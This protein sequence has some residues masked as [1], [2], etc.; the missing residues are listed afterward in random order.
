MKPN[1]SDIWKSLPWKKFQRCVFRLQKRIWKAIR[2]KDTAKAK[3][4][5][6]LLLSSRSAKWIAIRQ[7]TQ[8]NTG[9]KTA[10]ID[11]KTALTFRER[12]ELHNLLKNYHKWNHKGLREVPIPKKDGTKRILKIPTIA[13]RAWQC[14]LKLAIEP[15]HEAVFHARSYGFRPG[16]S[17]WDCQRYIYNN[18]RSFCNG[19]NKRVLELDISKC[20]DRIS[21]TAMMKRVIAPNHI[22][23]G[24]WKCLK[25]GINPEFPDQGTPQGGV[26]SPLLANVALD[27]IEAIHPS[28]RYAD[29]MVVFLKPGDNAS[30]ILDIIKSFLAE[31]GLEVNLK[32]T[33]VTAATDGFDFLG[34][35]FQVKPNGK[36]ICTPSKENYQS[37]RAKVKSIVNSSNYGAKTKAQKLAPVVRGWRNYHR[38]CDMSKHSLWSMSHRA[39][40]VFNK[41]KKLN[42]YEAEKLVKKAFL[43]V[44]WAANKHVMVKGDSSPYDGNLLY[45]SKR[46]SKLYDGPTEKVL[47]KQDHTC[48]ICGLSFGP[49]DKV[50]LHHKDGNHNNWKPNNLEAIHSHCHHYHHM[51]N[52]YV[53]R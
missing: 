33:Q 47:K 10:G 9:K 49:E 44:K 52:G 29:D 27:G 36:F 4:L 31:R 14:L 6:K 35:N 1:H 32:K 37:F 25:A 42:R 34:W 12:F 51:S 22:K 23:Q 40:T 43:T 48:A 50:E 20:F 15:T 7:V 41:E 3:S 21:H 39:F 45:W 30:L 46:N 19:A 17:T 13:D 16:R 5:Q 2:A 53:R 26:I 24:L 8:L 18:L 11:G 38:Y 28:V